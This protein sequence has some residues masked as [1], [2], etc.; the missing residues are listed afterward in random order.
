MDAATAW[1]QGCLVWLAESKVT[2]LLPWWTEPVPRPTEEGSVYTHGHFWFCPQGARQPVSRDAEDTAALT[3]T[4]S[5]VRGLRRA[6]TG[7]REAAS[8]ALEKHLTSPSAV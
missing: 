4:F 2:P 3:Q 6:G 7:P 8:Q 5:R 1:L